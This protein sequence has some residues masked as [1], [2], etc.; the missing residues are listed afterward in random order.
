MKRHTLS[1]V[2]LLLASLAA[3]D[4]PLVLYDNDG[5][6]V[7]PVVGF[8]GGD[9]STPPADPIVMI[10]H[11]DHEILAKLRSSTVLSFPKR[12][13]YAGTDCTG[14]VAIEYNVF[15]GEVLGDL[16]GGTYGIGV[17]GLVYFG[18]RSA[19]TNFTYQSWARDGSSCQPSSGSGGA[20]EASTLFTLNFSPPYRLE[21]NPLIFTDG[22]ESGDTSRW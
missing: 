1:V 16:Q 14:S 12:V 13:L 10:R 9:F 4:S 21:I 15:Q 19:E 20:L 3:A 11:D 2:V 6:I 5:E 18:P 8:M 17:G 7:G 22:F